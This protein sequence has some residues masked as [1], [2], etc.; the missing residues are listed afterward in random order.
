[1]ITE[2][3]LALEGLGRTGLAGIVRGYS[4]PDLGVQ[5]PVRVLCAPRPDGEWDW[6]VWAC[7]SASDALLEEIVR[8]HLHPTWCN[9]SS[10]PQNNALEAAATRLDGDSGRRVRL[11]SPESHLKNMALS[12]ERMMQSLLARPAIT[13]QRAMPV[14]S[15]LRLLDA[16]VE[17]GRGD[18]ALEI[19]DVLISS[20]G[21][22][23]TDVEFI[24]C[25]CLA[26][27]RRHRDVLEL[28]DLAQFGMLAVVPRGISRD[29][30]R[31]IF[32]IEI[33][34]S[35]APEAAMRAALRDYSPHITGAVLHPKAGS[36]AEE[37][38]VW[39]LL[40]DDPLTPGYAESSQEREPPT[41]HE[42]P[43]PPPAQPEPEAATRTWVHFLTQYVDSLSDPL[44]G[45]EVHEEPLDEGCSEWPLWD[46]DSPSPA[47]LA[48]L[49][50]LITG[51]DLLPKVSGHIL[52]HADLEP[53]VLLAIAKALWETRALNGVSRYAASDALDRALEIG[54]PDPNVV[55]D[56]V[57]AGIAHWQ[58]Y[59]NLKAFPWAMDLA[60]TLQEHDRPTSPASTELL[61][62]LSAFA[63]QEL[64]TSAPRLSRAQFAELNELF[65]RAAL[66]PIPYPIVEERTP[67]TN[68]DHLKGKRVLIYSLIEHAARKAQGDLQR[69]C[70][71]AVIDIR[72]DH[73]CS[74]QL[75][76]ASKSADVVIMV[77]R[78]AKHAATECIQRHAR[79]ADI[80][81]A[82]GTGWSSILAQ[83]AAPIPNR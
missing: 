72:A 25:R 64:A 38:E 35:E 5:F 58:T 55:D 53:S 27:E 39:R 26:A 13:A 40:V 18:R 82:A 63:Q 28:A 2:S 47:T 77:T 29:I 1:M 36:T 32:A 67:D 37:R 41:P 11:V 71:S 9:R 43:Q 45:T 49:I 24:R 10:V 60:S 69:Q 50:E 12:T 78:A 17:A 61:G 30:A 56:V 15:A 42:A 79:N 48:E 83:A 68:F 19:A 75:V 80:R 59:A 4:T 81:F 16:E 14:A 76:Q 70:A 62:Y 3:E 73:D 52:A 20:E 57:A 51:Q 31:A 74:E 21:F 8:G 6:L 44:Q 66:D 65:S 54:P 22:S 33:E 46:Y 7:T 23:A 34:Q